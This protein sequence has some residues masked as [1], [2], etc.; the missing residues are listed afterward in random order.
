MAEATTWGGRAGE[1]GQTS[2]G[3]LVVDLDIPVELRVPRGRG[4]SPEQLFALG[5]GA[6]FRWALL[7][8]AAAR[9][10]DIADSRVRCRVSI[11]TAGA[12]GGFAL[13]VALD[14]EAP[15]LSPGDAAMLMTH[16]HARSP[17]SRATRGNI[18]VSLTANGAPLAAVMT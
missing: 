18:E 1:R 9:K 11:G 6:C 14:L 17:Y 16:A 13:A 12:G 3:R 4:T 10:L 5:F 2:D 8:V 7:G 15:N